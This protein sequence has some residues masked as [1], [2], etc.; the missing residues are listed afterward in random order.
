MDGIG[1][2]SLPAGGHESRSLL[3]LI[4]ESLAPRSHVIH[5][6]EKVEME[7]STICLSMIHPSIK[8]LKML[9]ISE[10]VCFGG[11]VLTKY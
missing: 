10:W 1:C 11:V 2:P 4:N 3:S 7:E 9:F 5:G 6:A 8:I